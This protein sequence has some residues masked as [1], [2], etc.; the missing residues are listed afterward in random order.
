MEG[1]AKRKGLMLLSA[2]LLTLAMTSG[3]FAYTYL[4]DTTTPLL[5]SPMFPKIL[6]LLRAIT[7]WVRL[8]AK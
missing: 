3:L 8:T 5:T 1:N 6:S 4:V 7:F 2:F